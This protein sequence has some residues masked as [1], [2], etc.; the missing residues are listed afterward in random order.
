MW[1][2]KVPIQDIL[3]LLV[4]FYYLRIK[5]LEPWKAFSK[6]HGWKVGGS[7]IIKDLNHYIVGLHFAIFSK[8]CYI[9]IDFS[10]YISEFK[11]FI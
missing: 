6:V 8:V 4:F 5:K 2:F 11:W 1:K 7:G 10:A 9:W 3:Y